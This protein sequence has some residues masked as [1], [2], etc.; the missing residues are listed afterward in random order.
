MHIDA[1]YIRTTRSVALAERRCERK[2][3]KIGRIRNE[4]RGPAKG[5]RDAKDIGP[6]PRNERSSWAGRLWAAVRAEGR[7]RV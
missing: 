2:K 6:K 3:E 5:T 7:E 4:A 1:Q